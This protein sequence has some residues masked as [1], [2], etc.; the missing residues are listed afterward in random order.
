MWTVDSTHVYFVR[1][2]VATDR[3]DRFIHADLH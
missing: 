1:K 3:G 2:P